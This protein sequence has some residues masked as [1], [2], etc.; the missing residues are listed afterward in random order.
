MPKSTNHRSLMVF[1]EDHSTVRKTAAIEG[2]RM[3]KLFQKIL[4]AYLAH[5]VAE[6]KKTDSD[7]E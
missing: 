1:T 6:P 5:P 4:R 7:P 3:D 2:M